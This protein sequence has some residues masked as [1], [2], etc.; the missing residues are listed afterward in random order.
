LLRFS[1]GLVGQQVRLSWAAEPGA[2]YRIE[3]SSDLSLGGWAQVSLVEATTAQGTWV[4][5]EK[6]TVKS[7][8]RITKPQPEVFSLEPPVVSNAGGEILVR[9]QLLP[10]G[11]SLVLD[12]DGQSL[13]FPLVAVVGQPG[14]W[15]ASISG[16]GL[17]GIAAARIVDSNGVTIAP[18]NQTIQVTQNGLALDGPPSLPPSSLYTSSGPLAGGLKINSQN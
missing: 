1:T 11:S 18:V 13:S 5:P 14:V 9:G 6:T 2:R 4:D 7:F 10:P 15:R 3:K 12:F 17:A 16:G 8:Y